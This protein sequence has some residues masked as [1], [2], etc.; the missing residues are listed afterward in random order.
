MP[1]RKKGAL[2]QIIADSDERLASF[3]DEAKRIYDSI[4][5]ATPA[6]ALALIQSQEDSR[7]SAKEL[8]KIA[9]ESIT[10]L[11]RRR[12]ISKAQL[13]E[14]ETAKTIYVKTIG[15]RDPKKGSEKNQSRAQAFRGKLRIH[16]RNAVKFNQHVSRN[17]LAN[18]VQKLPWATKNKR[19][20]RYP[21][22]ALMRFITPILEAA[23]TDLKTGRL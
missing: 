20:D 16:V 22:D 11:L 9:D 3:S 10:A 2:E 18:E 14:Y 15:K 5:F 4:L 6:E 8:I 1:K 17:G 21:K 12:P 19:G 13:A 7:L 23:K